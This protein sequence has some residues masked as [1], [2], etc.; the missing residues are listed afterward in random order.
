M[1]VLSDKAQ[2]LVSMGFVYTLAGI[3]LST[4]MQID[5]PTR[6]ESAID[7]SLQAIYEAD[8]DKKNPLNIHAVAAMGAIKYA[9]FGQVKSGAIVGKD[10][11]LFTSE[12]FD[13][14]P[15]FYHNLT[16]AADEIAQIQALL[17]ENDVTLIPVLVPDKADVYAEQLSFVRPVEVETR[18]QYLLSLLVVRG[19]P[20]ID[21]TDTLRS[22]KNSGHGFLKDDTHWSP[23]GS[24]AVAKLVAAHHA[25]LDVPLT[26]VSVTTVQGRSNTF[27]GDLLQFVPT[28]SFRTSIGPAQQHI[29]TFTTT[30]QTEGGMFDDTSVDVALVGTS[31]SAKSDWN[32]LGFLQASLGADVLNFAAEGQGP[33]AP[34]HAFL[35]SDT[36]LNET[37]K[38][39]IW[40]IPV[41]Y[42]S[43]EM[44]R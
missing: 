23:H 35:A 32:F 34:M 13:V 36:F 14:E 39:V 40:E 27:D 42:T 5:M 33:F 9:V 6:F 7:G 18:R 11:W 17:E 30:V 38:L 3:G 29:D 25:G 19:V 37:P 1:L 15:N 8:F 41:R 26:S 28:G 16:A 2:L 44:I 4:H 20:A 21:A 43:K 31:F 10:G 22:L 24:K 12:E